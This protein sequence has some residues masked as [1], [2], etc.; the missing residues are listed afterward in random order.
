MNKNNL[1]NNIKCKKACPANLE[2]S[3]GFSLIETIIAIFILVI[4]VTG[5]LAAASSSL[6]A[7]FYARDQVVAFY[8]AQDVIEA[9]KNYRDN[10]YMQ[11]STW[12]NGVVCFNNGNPCTVD[13]SN[14]KMNQNLEITHVNINP[15]LYLDES[16]NVFTHDDKTGNIKTRFKRTVVFDQ[17][18]NNGSKND[19]LQIVVTVEWNPR[20]ILSDTKKI[21]VQENIYNWLDFN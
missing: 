18:Y 16:K 10:Q 7:S 9:I 11:S 2:R 17:I 13:T 20:F 15:F 21:V 5:P 1:Q 4:A 8:L 19:E 3:G 6:K 12:L 14:L